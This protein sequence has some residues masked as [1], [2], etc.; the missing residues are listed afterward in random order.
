MSSRPVDVV[1]HGA[2][3]AGRRAVFAE[4]LA[5]RPAPFAGGDA[6]FGAGDGGRHDVGAA[7]GGAFQFGERV[8]DRR[9]VALRA[10]G[11]QPFD[12][13]ALGVF[14]HRHDRLDAAGERRGL[15]LEI[16]VDADDDLLAALDRFQ[17][18]GVRFDQLLLHVAAL[19]R[20]DRAAH[21]LDALELFLGLALERLDLAVDHLRAV[22][23]IAVVEQVGLVGE[24]LLH[25]QRPLLVPRPRQAERLVPRRQLHGAGARVLRQRHRQH[26][27]QDARDV[28]FGLLLGQAERV[29]LHAVAEQPLLGIGDAV[30]RARD[31][32][33]QFGEGAHLAHFGDEAQ[34]GIDEERDAPDHLAEFFRLTSPDA[35]TVSSTAIAVA[36]A[37]ASSCTGVA[38][39]S[40]RW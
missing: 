25:A 30:A 15:A 29:H 33:P 32:V 40:C 17:P 2:A 18:R 39:A 14:R 7:G 26:L 3:D 4:G 31:L 28:V 34:A 1:A 20:L 9:V 22:E 6:G 24:D 13:A 23:N 36:S 10:P 16:F 21:L 37:K 35:F 12:L 11:F 19:D 5:Q 8:V 27:E 38:P